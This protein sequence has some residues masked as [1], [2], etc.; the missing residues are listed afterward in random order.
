MPG[1]DR[2]AAE[3]AGGRWPQML[4][5]SPWEMASAVT[6]K[7]GNRYLAG[8]LGETAVTAGRTQ[9]R[10]GARYRRLARR[11]GK[12]KAQVAV[13]NT[14]AASPGMRYH[15]DDPGPRPGVSAA[16]VAVLVVRPGPGGRPHHS[17][18]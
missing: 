11:R 8:L 12:H 18:G 9:T 5:V 17:A 10:E 1:R 3:A 13:G 16:D 14:S 7:K 15:D 2:A 4:T 6:S